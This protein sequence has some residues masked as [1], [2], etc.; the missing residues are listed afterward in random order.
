MAFTFEPQHVYLLVLQK[1]EDGEYEL[2]APE[3]TRIVEV[4]TR[5]FPSIER[6]PRDAAPLDFAIDVLVKILEEE[7]GQCAAAIWLLERSEVFKG[8]LEENGI[9][10]HFVHTLLRLTKS[11][12]DEGTLNAAYTFLGR[13]NETS[14]IHDIIQF[15]TQEQE[16][17]ISKSN[18][19]NW[20]QGF[21][22]EQQINTLKLIIE[23]AHDEGVL[24]YAK[25]RLESHLG[26]TQAFSSPT[27]TN[28]TR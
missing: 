27:Q 14:A 17:T 2:P 26:T 24:E 7:E 19:I 25:Q 9:K 4:S 20:L 22:P 23:Q 11:A 10:E 15:I 28:E 13:L 1:A 5:T 12:Q 6:L 8:R 21:P 18:A 16:T 3:D